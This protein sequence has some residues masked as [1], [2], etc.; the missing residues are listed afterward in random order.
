MRRASAIRRG[1][2]SRHNLIGDRLKTAR[3]LRTPPLSIVETSRR[4]TQASGFQITRLMLAKIEKQQ[5]SVY[6]F[7]VLAFAEALG[8]D[9]RYLLG[10]IDDP[11]LATLSHLE[12][13]DADASELVP[14][15]R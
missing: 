1:Q 9:V 2:P 14:P 11:H 5:R 6:D 4:A 8:V 10:V 12:K 15:G 7:E 3:L 13:E